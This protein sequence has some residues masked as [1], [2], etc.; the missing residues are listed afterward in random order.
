MSVKVSLVI[1][2]EETKDIYF[3]SLKS[4][5]KIPYCKNCDKLFPLGFPNNEDGISDY[6]ICQEN[7]LLCECDYF[8]KVQE[9]YSQGGDTEIDISGY[10]GVMDE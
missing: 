1:D 10:Y 7:Y 9:L 5:A 2:N 6:L 8:R 4:K 3:N